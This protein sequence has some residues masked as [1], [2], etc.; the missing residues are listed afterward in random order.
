MMITID[1]AKFA[2]AGVGILMGGDEAMLTVPGRDGF[3]RAR[4]VGDQIEV[5]PERSSSHKA[6][7]DVLA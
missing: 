3:V 5:I 6:L 4:I 7:V 1:A 2:E